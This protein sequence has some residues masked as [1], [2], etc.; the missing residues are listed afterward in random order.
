MKRQINGT[1]QNSKKILILQAQWPKENWELSIRNNKMFKIAKY[2]NSL[3]L[4]NL[5]E[6]YTFQVMKFKLKWHLSR[7]RLK[8]KLSPF[9]DFIHLTDH[10][11]A[12]PSGK[13][14]TTVVF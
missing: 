8:Y 12:C 2:V 13:M 7:Y 3:N 10:F 6:I 11:G 1:D 5:H 14:L 9:I 4:I